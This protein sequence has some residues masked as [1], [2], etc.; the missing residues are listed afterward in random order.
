ML[1]TLKTLKRKNK[2]ES[3]NGVKTLYIVDYDSDYCKKGGR[4]RKGCWAYSNQSPPVMQNGDCPEGVHISCKSAM[5][6]HFVTFKVSV[7]EKKGVG[8][9][10]AVFF[11]SSDQEG[12]ALLLLET[13]YIEIE[14]EKNLQKAKEKALQQITDTLQE[15]GNL[16]APIE[17]RGLYGLISFP[18]LNLVLATLISPTELEALYNTHNIQISMGN[19]A[20]YE[21][22]QEIKFSK[23]TP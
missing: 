8:Q 12:D 19:Y 4:N 22:P 17:N 18:I 14:T 13:K 23:E 2:L 16:E 11:P 6:L 15:L 20:R 10:D 1:K 5:D 3:H 7:W 21:S 9:C